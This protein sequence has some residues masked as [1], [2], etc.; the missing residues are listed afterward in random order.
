MLALSLVLL[1]RGPA[2]VVLTLAA[3]AVALS[4]VLAGRATTAR[5][6][7]AAAVDGSEVESEV[8]APVVRPICLACTISP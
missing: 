6:V 1:V 3:R 4:A 8:C 7:A 5:S 2:H